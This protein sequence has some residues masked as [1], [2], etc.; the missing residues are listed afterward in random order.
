MPTNTLDGPS[1]PVERAAPMAAH[2]GLRFDSEGSP[3]D[4][5]YRDVFRSRR[6]A[7]EESIAVFVEGADVASRWRGRHCF[8][9]LELGFGTG[10]NFLATLGR[11]LADAERSDR[12]DY[13]GIEAR[14]LSRDDLQRALAVLL[15]SVPDPDRVLENLRA[16]L[17]RQWPAQVPGFHRLRF[18]NEKVVLT[19]VV[20]PVQT[21]LRQLQLQADA[22]YL[23]GFAPASNPQMWSEAVLRGVARQCRPG[24]IVASWTSARLVRDRLSEAGFEVQRLPGAGGKR[25]RIVG[26]LARTHGRVNAPAANGRERVIVIGAGLAGAC[27]AQG[28]AHAGFEVEVVAATDRA[29]SLQPAMADHLHFSADDNALA[30]LSRAALLLRRAEDAEPARLACGRLQLAD[31]AHGD[32]PSSDE[33]AQAA[34]LSRQPWL[35]ALATLMDAREAARVSGVDVRRAGLW[36]PACGAFDPAKRIQAALAQPAVRMRTI[37]GGVARIAR[38]QRDLGW[39]VFASDGRCVASAPYVILACAG[40]VASLAG[41]KVLPLQALAGQSTWLDTP[42]LTG[43]RCV[44]GGDVVLTPVPGA[45]GSRVLVSASFGDAGESLPLARRDHE[46]LRKL[47]EVLETSQ[48]GWRNRIA[49]A[50]SAGIGVRQASPDRLPYIGPLFD[51]AAL[52]SNAQR[53]IRNDRLPYP[54][55]PGLYTACGFGSRGLLWAELA[56]ELI[57]SMMLGTT[58]PLASELVDAV[59]PARFA[60]RALRRGGL[61]AFTPA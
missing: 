57:P 38:D 17:L 23:D 14:L 54:M 32:S 31:K 18:A 60:R 21:A 33:A 12:L 45:A 7:W 49:Q 40:N 13:V 26:R 47:A 37:E 27:M 41:L 34:L 53:H 1:D 25:H 10:T 48:A 8:S 3:F 4:T 11:W 46:N 42:D 55:Q 16:E 29:A 51:E 19:L 9:I 15:A 58:P 5:E 22:V 24:G 2:P 61:H 35:P 50:H 6:G 28:L 52:L 36:I 30:R 59:D 56:A 20:A 44:L 43:L 39:E